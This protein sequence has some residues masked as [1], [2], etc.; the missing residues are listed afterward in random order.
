MPW[1]DL[2][3]F[4]NNVI[5]NWKVNS[6]YA[7]EKARQN[8]VANYYKPGP[9]TPEK[10]SHRIFNVFRAHDD[11]PFGEFYIAG[12]VMFGDEQVTNDNWNGGVD[13]NKGAVVQNVKSDKPFPFSPIEHETAVQAYQS[14]LRG[15]GASLVRDAV[16]RRIVKEV[17]TGTATY[18]GSRAN[19]PGIIDS[20]ND[21]GG[22]PALRSTPAPKDTDGDGMP[23]AWER[24][25]GLNFDDAADGSAYQLS[26]TFTNLEV[27]LNELV[28]KK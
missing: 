15:S 7:G 22:Y 1:T 17:E 4:R 26:A 23:D 8:I 2:V 3:D 19:L 13:L 16:D 25:K 21:V 5:Y 14:V 27:Y 9:A 10:V 20:Q 11:L 24:K 28:E 12:N 18:R 6:S